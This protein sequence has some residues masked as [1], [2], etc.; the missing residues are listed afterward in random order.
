MSKV[1]SERAG[2]VA[3]NAPPVTLMFFCL[4]VSLVVP[5]R[6]GV[7][8]ALLGIPVWVSDTRTA[9]GLVA[10]SSAPTATEPLEFFERRRVYSGIPD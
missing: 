8:L 6:H 4:A 3:L 9:T 5:V 1:T 2:T 10:V 7:A